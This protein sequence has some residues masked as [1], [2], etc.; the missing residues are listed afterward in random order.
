MYDHFRISPGSNGMRLINSQEMQVHCIFLG[1]ATHILNLEGSC[2]P[3]NDRKSQ[4]SDLGNLEQGILPGSV[5]TH[6]SPR[7]FLVHP[8]A[9]LR[10]DSER[11]LVRTAIDL[12]TCQKT[13]P[14]E[15][16][17]NDWSN[18]Q[19]LNVQIYQ[20]GSC[21]RK[22]TMAMHVFELVSIR[23]THV[24]PLHSLARHMWCLFDA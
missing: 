11:L 15:T 24:S 8:I 3:I 9:D 23:D 1:G 18:Y 20:A 4:L 16:T 14:N 12:P 13:T 22:K 5:D 10:Q 17:N 7:H 19:N 21:G 2:S 6:R